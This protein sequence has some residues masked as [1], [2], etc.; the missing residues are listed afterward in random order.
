M[1]VRIN[2]VLCVCVWNDQNAICA[3][4]VRL[5]GSL[6]FTVSTFQFLERRIFRKGKFQIGFK[7]HRFKSPCSNSR[8]ISFGQKS[9]RAQLVAIQGGP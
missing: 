9:P 3:S 5:S 4:S 6:P 2:L 8:L 7:L 1:T